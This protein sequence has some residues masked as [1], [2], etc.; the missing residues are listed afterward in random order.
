MD[1]GES[2]AEWAERV[3]RERS[4]W[5]RRARISFVALGI[6]AVLAIFMGCRAYFMPGALSVAVAT[7][8]ACRTSDDG[9]QLFAT[10]RLAALRDSYVTD[11]TTFDAGGREIA[12]QTVAAALVL[13]GV[14]DLGE[15]TDAEVR[16]L[17]AESV[18]ELPA[19]FGRRGDEDGVLVVVID[20]PDGASEGRVDGITVHGS[21]GEIANEQR[22][23]LGISY[24][25]A[26]CELAVSRSVDGH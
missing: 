5:R 16:A 18:H 10:V 24:G 8:L 21:I 11:V 12:G 17:P 9:T 1:T 20:L 15:L 13:G 3:V 26:E 19:P 25:S 4:E 22:I 2:P 6:C 7:P 14:D 23:P